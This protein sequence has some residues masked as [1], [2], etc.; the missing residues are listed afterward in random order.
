MERSEEINKIGEAL[1]KAQGEMKAAVYDRVNPYYKSKYATLSAV[2]EA[3]KPSLSKYNIAVV[4]GTSF[5]METNSVK[6]ETMLIHTSGQWI[7]ETLNMK[8]A[9][10]DPQ[11]VGSSITYAR[12]YSLASLVGIAADEDDD[13]TA[14]VDNKKQKTEVKRRVRKTKNDNT[15]VENIPVIVS[16]NKPKST[17]KPEIKLKKEVVQQNNNDG[18]R[19]TILKQIFNC[20]ARLGQTPEDMKRKISDILGFDKPIES[21]SE[22][23][24]NM[25]NQVL[26]EFQSLVINNSKEAA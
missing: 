21:S 25:I 18:G 22:I 24:D 17:I 4:Q 26:E 6:V 9:K 3:C 8:P 13:G 7:S 5:D 2:M 10:N 11:S 14:S 19:L 12:R 23:P 1:A 16:S 15:P 20:S